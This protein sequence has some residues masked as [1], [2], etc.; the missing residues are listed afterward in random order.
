MTK[1]LCILAMAAALGC[2]SSSKDIECSRDSNCNLEADGQCQ[3]ACSGRKWCS[4]P[5]TDCP[6][7][8]RWSDFD[9]GDDLSGKCLSE[10]TDLCL[11]VD[12]GPDAREG[13]QPDA[14][15]VDC[16][17]KI[18]FL[19]A[20]GGNFE[21]FSVKPDGSEL[22]NLTDDPGSDRDPAWSADGTKI[23]WTSLRDGNQEVYVM[24]ADGTGV[25]NITNNPADDKISGWS[26]DGQ[27]L[28]FTSNRD[29]GSFEVY[30]TNIDGSGVTRLTTDEGSFDGAAT[31]SR[32]STRIA[33][34]SGADAARLVRAM[35][36]NGASDN[37]V[38]SGG[39]PVSWS[40]TED[41]ILYLGLAAPS[42]IFVTNDTGTATVNLT[43]SNAVDRTPAW[44]P[45]GATIAFESFRDDNWEIYTMNSDGSNQ[46]NT[47]NDATLDR[48][49][50][51]GPGGN[52]VAFISMRDGERSI[53]KMDS[54][55]T[56]PTKVTSEMLS[57]EAQPLWSPC[58]D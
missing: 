18:L 19:G 44:S 9:T 25:A 48:F 38:A 6:S 12:A 7:G 33:Y 37:S 29:D 4:Y 47:S 58:G 57:G 13:D 31:V 43:N 11:P 35:N 14:G 24:N 30:R 21:I 54:D 42:D 17:E 36:V 16:E 2:G 56:N 22:T 51:W 49:P 20:I 40:P 50:N 45:D 34:A 28:L 32:S 39:A 55:G 27:F 10:E 1:S 53:W 3:T 23:A 5:D 15:N 41:L 46:T 52:Q 8:T 26:P